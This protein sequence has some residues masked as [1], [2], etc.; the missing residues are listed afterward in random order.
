MNVHF[1]P[2]SGWSIRGYRDGSYADRSVYSCAWVI[3]VLGAK[4]CE[5]G[6]F[7]SR[8]D[9]DFLPSMRRSIESF[10]RDHGFEIA[11]WEDVTGGGVV[12]K[13]VDLTR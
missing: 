6:P 5:V 1:A 11:T 3:N 8:Y 7:I 13:T 2:V 4:H 12:L 10:C 9:G